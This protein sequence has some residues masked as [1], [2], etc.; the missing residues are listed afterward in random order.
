MS[1]TKIL[2]AKWLL[3][4]A[5]GSELLTDHA[6]VIEGERIAAVLPTAEAEAKYANAER[7]EL[8]QHV[9]IPGLING[10]THSAMS[11]L[12]GV[13]DDLALMDW[14]NNHIWP[15][16]KKWVSEDWTYQGSLLSA[17]EAL[18]GGVT[19]LPCTLR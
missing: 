15:L 18:R 2:K 7:V 13:A 4:M 10:H 9:L 3:T 19:Y 11:L 14:L 12:R 5:P 8:G 6:L 1:T 16:E 17:A